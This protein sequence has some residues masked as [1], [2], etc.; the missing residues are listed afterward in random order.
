MIGISLLII[1]N[2]KQRN[3]L[4]R[5]YYENK[6]RFYAI[7][8]SKLHKKEQ[9]EDAVQELFLRIADN[10]DKFFEIPLENRLN[11]SEVILRN[12]AI[13]IFNKMN[14]IPEEQLCC[15][16][17]E[18]NITL[19]DSLFD[20]ISRDEILEFVDNLPPTQRNVLIL[21]CFYGFSID[22]VSQR[23]N[24]SLDAANK[25]LTLARKAVRKFIDER[26][27]DYE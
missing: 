24:I 10:P 11:Y 1:E 6:N 27:V 3:E 4:T 16:D 25:R 12:I 17:I 21:R 14:K 7:A 8:M 9:S 13:D 20:R 23:L 2:E 15:E 26:N 5:F 18:D 22:E 19:E